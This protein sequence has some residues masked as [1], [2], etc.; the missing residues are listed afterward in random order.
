MERRFAESVKTGAP[1]FGTFGVGR[2]EE[3]WN[4]LLK[5]LIMTEAS[6][7]KLAKDCLMVFQVDPDEMDFSLLFADSRESRGP[8]VFIFW[9]TKRCPGEVV[10]GNGVGGAL[11]VDTG[12]FSG[13]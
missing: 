13:G 8:K 3:F 12:V 6:D 10:D 5:P 7:L 11:I 1:L 4:R 9:K 2:V